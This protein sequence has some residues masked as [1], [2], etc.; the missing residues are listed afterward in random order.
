MKEN[1]VDKE[2]Q[3]SANREA[4]T[5]TICLKRQL[6]MKRDEGDRDMLGDKLEAFLNGRKKRKMRQRVSWKK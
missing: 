1:Y 3:G 5:C 6:Q 2:R 4:P